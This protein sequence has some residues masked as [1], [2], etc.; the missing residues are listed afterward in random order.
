MCTGFFEGYPGVYN[1][2]LCPL[3]NDITLVFI[4]R[5]T[6]TFFLS[7]SGIV[8]FPHPALFWTFE[9]IKRIKHMKENGLC[10]FCVLHSFN[11]F[12][13]E[14]RNQFSKT[15]IVESSLQLFYGI[16]RR[17]K[18][19]ASFITVHYFKCKYRYYLQRG[20]GNQYKLIR[21]LIGKKNPNHS[22]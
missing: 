4:S 14:T 7:S 18:S 5:L 15:N 9:Y 22:V 6:E 13:K 12:S 10:I 19:F 17:W 1:N 16:T 2:T 8:Q 11:N 21:R 20:R 3:C